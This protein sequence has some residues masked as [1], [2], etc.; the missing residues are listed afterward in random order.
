MQNRGQFSS[1]FGFLM[2]A[3]GSA[4]GLGNIWSFPTNTASNG[5]GAFVLMYFALAFSL[6][7]PALMAELI[8][9]RHTRSNIVTALSGAGQRTST[10]TIGRFTGLYGVLVAS[11]ILSFYALVA[12]WMI[13][14]LL[15]SVAAVA[16]YEYA[17]AWLT[18]FGTARNIIFCGIFSLLTIVVVAHG[19]ERGI[20]RWSRRLMPALIVLMFALIAYV[21]TLPGAMRGLQLYL[22]PDFARITDPQ[23][24]ISALGQ[25]FFSLSLGVGTM[26]I[27]GSYMRAEENLPTTGAM[28]TLIDTAIAF[29]AGLIILPALFAAQNKGLQIYNTDGGLISGP[30]LIFD[31]LPML[32]AAMGAIGYLVSFAFFSLLTIAALTSSISMLEVPVAFATERFEVSRQRLTWIVGALIFTCSVVIAVNFDTLFARVV[33]VTTKYSQPLLGV[34]I[35]VFAGWAFNR[36]RLLTEIQRGYPS[37]EHSL[38]WKLWPPYVRYFCPLLI[39]AVF[40]QAVID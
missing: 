2:A 34:V 38:F 3:T 11:L 39:V 30:G 18:S 20:E 4:V 40:V 9:G 12:G 35:C 24:L 6:A 1:R 7:Y 10:R 8:I 32:F 13:A 27:Y 31:T 14:H 22:L 28:V 23:L 26:M 17:L 29:L 21:L 37:A 33:D 15:T 19:I 36:N 16:Q 5:G 25:A